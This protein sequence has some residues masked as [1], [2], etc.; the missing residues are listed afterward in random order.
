M[1]EKIGSV[2][3]AHRN[4]SQSD[5]MVRVKADDRWQTRGNNQDSHKHPLERS[6]VRAIGSP[7]LCILSGA[8]ADSRTRSIKLG[9]SGAGVS[10]PLD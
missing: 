8:A 4:I 7:V 2:Q 10:F 3:T 6:C 1:Q 9:I 5:R